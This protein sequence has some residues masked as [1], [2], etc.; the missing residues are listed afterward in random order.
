MDWILYLIVYSVLLIPLPWISKVF[1]AIKWQ[2]LPLDKWNKAFYRVYILYV[3]VYVT[4]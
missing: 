2:L 1:Q 3:P 4:N